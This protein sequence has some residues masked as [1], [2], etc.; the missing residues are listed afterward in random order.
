MYIIYK[1][2]HKVLGDSFLLSPTT[3]DE[4]Q[5]TDK[6]IKHQRRTVHIYQELVSVCVYYDRQKTYNFSLDVI[7]FRFRIVYTCGLQSVSQYSES[8]K[9]NVCV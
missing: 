5:N 3:D 4:I 9:A 6:Q 8:L 2:K 1:H 7:Y